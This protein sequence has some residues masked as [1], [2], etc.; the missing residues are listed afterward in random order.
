MKVFA[1]FLILF[2][3]F[4]VISI[5]IA[6]SN[7]KPKDFFKKIFT[8][9]KY[10]LFILLVIAVVIILIGIFYKLFDNLFISGIFSIVISLVLLKF[11]DR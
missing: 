2:S 9:I 7:G 3:V 8:H 10:L 4:I 1:Y 5:C 11:L 6:E